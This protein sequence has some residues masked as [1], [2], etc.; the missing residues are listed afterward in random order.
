M[1]NLSPQTSH[2]QSWGGYPKTNA[3][4]LPLQWRHQTPDWQG[5]EPH[6]LA[7]GLGRSYG[8]ACLNDDG[9]LLQ[10]RGLN[11]LMSFDAATGDLTCEAGISLKAILEFAVPRGFFLP[12]TPGTQWVTLGGAIANDVHGKNH[13]SAG[14]LGCHVQAFELLRSD[15]R[16]VCSP[17]QDAELFAATI[18]G[19]GLTGVITWATLRLIPV[20]SAMVET[21]TN[22]FGSLSEFFELTHHRSATH[23]YSV[24][25]IDCFATRGDQTR[26]LFM[27]GNHA[28]VGDLEVAAD[29]KL[30]VPFNA[31]NSLLNPLT[32]KAF[33]RL[34]YH[35]QLK[36]EAQALQHYA[37]F[38][39]P[40]DSLSN[41]N[42]IYGKRG[43]LQFQSVTPGL[44]P[45]P[46][47]ALLEAIR[48]AN[49][50]S[51]LAVLKVFGDVPSPGLMSF[52][53]AGVTLALDFP[54][55]GPQTF[56]LMERLSAIVMEAGGR[57]YP[58]KDAC[59][60]HEMFRAGF[61]QWQQLAA[62]AD[63]KFSSSF[64]RRVTASA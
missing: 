25:W 21:L 5:L 33:N 61:P 59:M 36:R 55:C 39:Y 28:Q 13:H 8:D 29:A 35:R 16:F 57:L 30:T 9:V 41:W 15:G 47:R 54:I 24:A 52:P 26:G 18:G 38:F 62:Q 58:A 48:D 43:F 64:W 7:Y 22:K 19:L 11:R 4:T 49:Q 53:M 60:S 2:L 45:A 12:V 51:F 44:D 32:I 46:T 56:A 50:G 20:A 37:P 6:V 63:P 14:T 3:R 23:V 17:Q 31:P 10:T 42:R 40:L 27:A 34:Y 1:S